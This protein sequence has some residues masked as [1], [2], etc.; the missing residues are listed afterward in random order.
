MVLP[1]LYI[2]PAMHM[3]SYDTH[4]QSPYPL[5]AYEKG[6]YYRSCRLNMNNFRRGWTVKYPSFL[7][8]HPLLPGSI[9][10]PLII[11]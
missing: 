7:P 9:P 6:F 2:M 8:I 4:T 11:S 3:T 5:L 10:L 1:G